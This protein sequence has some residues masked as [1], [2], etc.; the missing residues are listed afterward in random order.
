MPRRLLTG[1]RIRERRLDHGL[2]QTELAK[3]CGISPSYLNLI[4]HNRRS[5]G[6]RL[7]NRIA[8]FLDTEPAALTEGA[9]GTVM[10]ALRTAAATYP[11]TRPE[12]DRLE[13]FADRFPGWARLSEAQFREAQRLLRVVEVLNDR[14]THDPFL[15]ASMH[16]IL[17]SVTAIRST[18]GILAEGGA[19]EIEWQA[20]F[21]RNIYEDSQRLAQSA[22]ALVS[23]LDAGGDAERGV[24]LPQE[25][26]EAWL[27]ETGW[28]IEAL[29]ADPNAEAAS[30]LDNVG[31]LGSTAAR[32]LAAQHLEQY[33]SDAA[34]VPRAALR[35][36]L[37][38]GVVQPARL[39]HDF[40]VGLPVLFRRL[41]ALPP[42]AFPDRQ[43]RGLV[44]C[45]GSGTL[46]YRKPVHGF[47]LPRYS[48][49]CPLWPLYQALQRPMVPLQQRIEMAGGD[50]ARFRITALS[51]TDYP[52]G[53]DGPAV[54]RSWMLIEPGLP[55]D[56]DGGEARVGVSCRICARIECP[57][58]REPSIV[59]QSG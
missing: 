33:R 30:I 10:N 4:E 47:D 50:A 40:G 51:L 11:R 22:E 7:L 14:L 2:R 35:E 16:D 13:E 9:E 55:S 46:V 57:A 32:R 54:T 52:E 56:G 48:A 12:L 59:A 34:A 19:I 43:P 5:I 38:R 3:M 25:E 31:S 37:R 21:H 42:E 6:G 39:A 26:L 41:A 15:S 8:E 24:S 44:G 45:D 17:S 27:S 20:R 1:T 58:R 18:S 28:S 36:K 29:E 23:Y 49:A 53:Y